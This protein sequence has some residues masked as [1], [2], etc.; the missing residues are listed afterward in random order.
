VYEMLLESKYVSHGKAISLFFL[1]FIR[2]FFFL[3]KEKV[4]EKKKKN[5]ELLDS[6]VL[7]GKRRR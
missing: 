2:F 3:V 6:G 4:L 1:F 5:D 7:D